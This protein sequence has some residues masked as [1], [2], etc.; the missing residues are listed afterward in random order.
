MSV[1][2]VSGVPGVG[3]SRVTEE[4]R[5]LLDDS[6]RVVNFGDVM[7]EDAVAR[8]MT[9]NRDEIMK[10]PLH[11]QSL[12]QRRAGE[13]IHEARN[14]KSLIVDTHFVLHTAHG[15][16]P[17]LPG[18]VLRDVNPDRLVLVEAEPDT[19]VERRESGKYRD[20]PEES[21]ATVSFHQQLNQTAAMTYSAQ[22]S[23]PILRV[24]NE[25]DVE[26]AG[27]RLAEIVRDSG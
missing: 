4:A 21:T 11:D 25:G 24:S 18:P 14:E 1:T 5:K 6:Y 8:G 10:L 16:V 13:Y 19:I 22:T 23:A 15:F 2:L 9:S 17:G 26:E 3:S 27:K 7:L 20:Y 12:L